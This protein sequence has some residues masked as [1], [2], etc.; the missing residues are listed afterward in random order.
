MASEP[1]RFKGPDFPPIDDE[2][3]AKQAEEIALESI[4][5]SR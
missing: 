2:F 5:L 3:Y 1:Y 4:A